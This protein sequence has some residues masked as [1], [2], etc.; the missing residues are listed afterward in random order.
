MAQLT[1]SA[2]VLIAGALPVKE[3]MAMAVADASSN[4]VTVD[5]NLFVMALFFVWKNR[6]C[7]YVMQQIR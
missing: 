7:L 5:L 3:N 1:A 4:A 2:L 6:N